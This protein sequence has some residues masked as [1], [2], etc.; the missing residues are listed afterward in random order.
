[1][2]FRSRL[3]VF[4]VSAGLC[5]LMGAELQKTRVLHERFEKEGFIVEEIMGY[6]KSEE[7]PLTDDQA[8]LVAHTVY[9][10]SA[11]HGMD[12]RLILAVMKVE[13]HFSHDAT[14]SMG[15]RGLLQVKPSLAR[16]IAGDAGV[17]WKGAR[18][19]DEP[20]ENIKIGV[21]FLRQ[22]LRDFETV[23]LALHAYNVGPT[24]VKAYAP[25]KKSVK[26]V[27][28]RRVLE[29]YSRNISILPDAEDQ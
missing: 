29:E 3:F 6:L 12:Y 7:V 21:F 22:L 13:S 19:L 8:R 10:E 24:R 20:D 1:M 17:E 11:R 4:T 18:T 9:Q 16:H 26:R 14:S 28:P 15:A 23:P 27:F 5:L 2:K 25:A